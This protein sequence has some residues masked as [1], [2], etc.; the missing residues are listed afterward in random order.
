MQAN[1]GNRIQGI[2]VA[3]L[4]AAI[5]GLFNWV[6]GMNTRVAILEDDLDETIVAV[7]QIMVP[8]PPKAEARV[9][10]ARTVK[11]TESRRAKRKKLLRELRRQKRLDRR[12]APR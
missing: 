4:I 8:E 5:I 7:E 1:L 12:N 2:V 3:L 10:S 11:P 9:E 6:Q